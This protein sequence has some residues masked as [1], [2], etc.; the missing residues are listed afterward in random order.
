MV[1]QQSLP[2]VEQNEEVPELPDVPEDDPA[3]RGKVMYKHY[4]FH[5]CLFVWCLL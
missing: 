4:S 1:F 2:D 3:A 5:G